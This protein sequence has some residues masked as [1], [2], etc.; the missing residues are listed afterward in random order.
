MTD[1]A[2]P[3]PAAR[4]E[5][6]PPRRT[7]VRAVL[8]AAGS[9]AA[10][11]AIY[12]LLPVD[13]SSTGVAAAMLA[14]GLVALIALVVFQVRWILRSRFPGLRG[15]K[16]SPPASRCSCCCSRPVL[17]QNPAHSLTCCFTI[18]ARAYPPRLPVHGPRVR[19]AGAP[20]AQ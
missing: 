6:R 3:E 14:I 17:C 5:S 20:G 2:D 4:P 11:V 10:L 8:R 19:L 13:R 7:I 15:S 18:G 9:T 1:H 16:P 12:Y